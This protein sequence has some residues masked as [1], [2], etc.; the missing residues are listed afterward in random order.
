[1][2]GAAGTIAARI[3]RTNDAGR[4]NVGNGSGGARGLDRACTV[5]DGDGGDAKDAADDDDD[6]GGEGGRREADADAAM[7]RFAI[8]NVAISRA[9]ECTEPWPIINTR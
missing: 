7:F 4:F 9:E 1:M 2:F 8:K 3:A 6:D 5:R